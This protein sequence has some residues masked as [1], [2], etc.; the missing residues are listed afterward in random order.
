M[1]QAD[2]RLIHECAL[3]RGLVHP[4]SALA[5][6]ASNLAEARSANAPAPLGAILCLVSA[7]QTAGIGPTQPTPWPPSE[8]REWRGQKLTEETMRV[9]TITELLRLTRKELCDLAARITAD[10]APLSR[11]IGRTRQRC[12]QPAQHPL[13]LSPGGISR[14]DAGGDAPAGSRLR[15]LAS[16]WWAFRFRT[17]RSRSSLLIRLLKGRG[18][19]WVFEFFFF[20]RLFRRSACRLCGDIRRS[21]H[22]ELD[23]RWVVKSEAFHSAFLDKVLGGGLRRRPQPF[24]A[25]IQQRSFGLAPA[26]GVHVCRA[27][28]RRQ[29]NPFASIAAVS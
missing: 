5:W 16:G 23:P 6:M 14:R 28:T 29:A 12:H 13:V 10:L 11:G 18:F 20:P 19:R 24:I 27:V 15:G 17:Q 4:A 22:A 1:R 7:S 3:A 25:S 2:L 8:G 26:L 21:S 9:L